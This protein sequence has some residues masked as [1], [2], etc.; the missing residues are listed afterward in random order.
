LTFVDVSD[1]S[2]MAVISNAAFG[3]TVA[4][5]GSATA[6][7]TADGSRAAI[8]V[9]YPGHYVYTFDVATGAQFMPRFA[10]DNQPNYLTVYGPDDRVGVACTVSDSATIW[11]IEGL[12]GSTN[13]VDVSV[14][15]TPARYL[16]PSAPN[17]C[18]ASTAVT[19]SIPTGE[20]AASVHLGV[21]DVQGRLV[22]MLVDG[23]RPAG[24]HTITWDG[25][26]ALGR[27]VPRGTYL[28]RI[29]VDGES[30]SRKVVVL[31]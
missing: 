5:Q 1:P 16:G 6:A 8:P 29:R 10:V 21:Y 2:D 25:T 18:A 24:T 7:F 20:R 15:S 30:D 4:P 13:A 31:R 27:E 28:F 26:D 9:V 23:S 19:Y 3:G 12:L 11:L 14:R 17:P 22:R